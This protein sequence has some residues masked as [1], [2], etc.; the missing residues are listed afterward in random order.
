MT[1]SCAVS[2]RPLAETFS[3]T[4]RAPGAT[5]AAPAATDA[6]AVPW[7]AQSIGSASSSPRSSPPTTFAF[8]NPPP[9]RSGTV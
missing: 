6:T 9:P 8:G 1:E 3:A 4:M 2:H 5:P 7:P